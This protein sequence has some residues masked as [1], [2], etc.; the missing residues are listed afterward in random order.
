MN[1]LQEILEQQRLFQ[2]AVNIP[3][4]SIL[5]DDRNR[6]SETFLWLMTKEIVELSRE[7]PSVANPWSKHQK[8]ADIARIKEE[9]A[10]VMLFLLNFALVWKFQLD[11]TLDILEK[12]QKANFV[13]IK[14]KKMAMLNADILKIPNRLSGTGQGS[15]SPK[16]VFVGQNPSKG[17]TQGY[18]FWSDENDGSSQILLPLL[19]ELGIEDC[20]F[21]NIVKCTTHDNKEP[22]EDL[23]KF[24]IEFYREEIKILQIANPDMKVIALGKWAEANIPWM[25][26][27]IKH[28]ASVLYGM[29]LENYREHV[30]ELL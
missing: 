7:I 11:D 1:R 19:R 15:L 17:I 12:T 4:D 20:Y 22:D 6:M 8:I 27:A 28:P 23:T 26:G 5:E 2:R 25:D 16:W 13:K 29:S 9:F 21:T 30:K 14:T 18:K 10:D 3:I 24:Y